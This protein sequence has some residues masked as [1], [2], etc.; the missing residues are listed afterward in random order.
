MKKSGSSGRLERQ[1]T[2]SDR[3]SSSPQVGWISSG[4]HLVAC[5]LVS[6]GR[7]A[8]RGRDLLLTTCT[9]STHTTKH[10]GMK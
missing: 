6:D 7:P 8:S 2:W 9:G 1:L 10:R 5:D 4:L 3:W